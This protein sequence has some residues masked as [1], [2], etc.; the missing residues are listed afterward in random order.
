MSIE[1]LTAPISDGIELVEKLLI[2]HFDVPKDYANDLAQSEISNQFSKLKDCYL[3]AEAPYVDKVYRDSFYHYYSSKQNRYLRDCIR[4]SFFECE[5]MDDDFQN[6]DRVEILKKLYRGFIVLRPTTPYIIGRNTISPKLLK[7]NTFL[8]CST[9]VQTTVS[10]VKMKV[11][12]F[13]HSSQDTETMTCAETTLWAIMEYFG[14]KYPDYK[15]T[16][17]SKIIH[18]LNKVSTERQ[19]P[20]RGL[21]IEQMSFALKEFGFGTRIYSIKEYGEDNFRR[22]FSTYIESGIPLI[23]G[24]DNFHL[25]DGDIGHAN[26]CIGHESITKDRLGLID[27]LPENH[28]L[29]ETILNDTN[30]KGLKISDWDDL[31]KEFVFIDDNFPSYQKAYFDNPT[32]HYEPAWHTCKIKHFIVPLYPKIYLEAYEAKNFALKLLTKSPDFT[33][34]GKSVL[35][36]FYLA[37]SRSYKDELALNQTFDHEV[38]NRILETPM[39]KFIWVTELTNKQ[40]I[41]NKMADGLILLDATEAN[42][43]Y[44]KPLIV[45]AYEGKYRTISNFKGV[46]I[47]LQPFIIYESNLKNL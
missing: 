21:N 34:N 25:D 39:A 13:P 24:L 28:D 14:T 33:T 41:K 15:P 2:K 5:I 29:P 35:I 46:D 10:S 40:L 43:N 1:I 22:L 36:R 38:K 47:S 20:S 45:A 11:D 4:I 37:S 27:D 16:L 32:E 44:R 8:C 31:N 30:S 9:T 23:V 3:V 18:T 6:P 7:E 12:G 17:P 19:I 26:I 42:I